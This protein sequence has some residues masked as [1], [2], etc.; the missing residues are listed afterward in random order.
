MNQ[1]SI[2]INLIYKSILTIANPILGILTFPYISRVLG[3]GNVGLVNFV[4]NTISY[5]LL[6]ASMGISTIGVRAIAAS[7]NNQDSLNKVFSNILGLNLIFTIV[8]LILY[9]LALVYIPRFSANI[10]LFLIGNAKIIFT[11]LL[12]EWFYSGIENFRFITIRSLLIRLIYVFLLFIVIK[13]PRDYV[14]YFILTTATIVV[15]SVVNM[16]Y[17]L[18]LVKV[19]FKELFSFTYLRENLL[20]G[21]YSIMTSMYLT[22]NVMFLGLR[23]NDIEVGY[24]TSAFKLYN[25]MLSVFTAF[26]SVMLPRM[27]SLIADNNFAQ[28]NRFTD[29][30]FESVSLLSFPIILCSALLAPEIIDLICG[31]GYEGAIIP[32]QII[33]PSI[34][35]VAISQVLA[36]QVLMP[37]KRDNILLRTSIF[38]AISSI[39]LNVTLVSKFGSVGS[40]LVL[41]FSELIVTIIYVIYVTKNN[42]VRIPW[43][44]FFKSFVKSLPCAVVCLVYK[45]MISQ[46]YVIIV[47]SFISSVLVYGLINLDELRNLVINRRDRIFQNCSNNE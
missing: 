16:F 31:P 44:R 22:F 21:V 24:Y 3:V 45:S 34:F 40:S 17:S 41:M 28:F 11:S 39:I 36:I 30:S 12:I 32:M 4:D 9:N 43:G 47:L 15:N 6:F 35:L 2:R 29:K 13:D 1:T 46:P 37:L 25:L 42:I 33:M 26:T 27:S 10:E 19:V 23:T 5:F 14:L 38:G 20:I 18:K 8:V 7:K